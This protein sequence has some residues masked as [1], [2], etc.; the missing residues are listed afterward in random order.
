[1][2][3]LVGWA[4]SRDHARSPQMP[5]P[6]PD[7]WSHFILIAGDLCYDRWSPHPSRSDGITAS[8]DVPRFPPPPSDHLTMDGVARARAR[9]MDASVWPSAMPTAS[10]D[11]VTIHGN[12]KNG[13]LYF[14]HRQSRSG[15]RAA[16]SDDVT[17]HG[18][19]N[20]RTDLFLASQSRPIFSVSKKTRML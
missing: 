1:M 7:G 15:A 3:F 18:N 2:F 9:A 17:I 20:D 16:S 4:R 11:E 12:K 19:K 6:P 5:P 14:R 8:L 10:S 13:W